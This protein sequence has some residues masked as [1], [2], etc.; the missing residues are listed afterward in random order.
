MTNPQI[1]D[2]LRLYFKKHTNTTCKTVIP[3][4]QSGSARKYY[5]LLADGIS[6]IGVYNN[7]KPENQAFLKFT[8]HFQTK[9]FNVPN[10]HM[11]D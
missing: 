1:I 7:N 10:I 5:R 9:D 6:L 11:F 2:Q 8:K 4:E 3:I